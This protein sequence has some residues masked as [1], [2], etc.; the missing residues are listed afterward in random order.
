MN[1]PASIYK[2]FIVLR[3]RNG[4]QAAPQRSETTY[5]DLGKGGR[6]ETNTSM[7]H[8]KGRDLNRPSRAACADG[9]K[10][11]VRLA[12]PLSMTA[13]DH[14]GRLFTHVATRESSGRTA[15]RN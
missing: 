5:A 1:E 14:A 2:S 9:R 3:T 10:I 6:L 4:S 13:P 11:D 8:M 15:R 12:S 7:S